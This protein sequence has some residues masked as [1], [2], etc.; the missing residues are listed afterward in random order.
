MDF[1]RMVVD[2]YAVEKEALLG[3]VKRLAATARN[4]GAMVIHVVVGFQLGYPEVSGHL[5]RDFCRVSSSGGQPR[6]GTPSACRREN[7][8]GG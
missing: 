4:S 5:R 3:R 7:P 8:R 6:P 2:S 1:Q